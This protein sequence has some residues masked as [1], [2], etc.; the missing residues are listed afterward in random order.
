M[1]FEINRSGLDAGQK[2]LD[3]TS[4]NIANAN[5]FGFKKS[6]A[7]FVDVFS[8]GQPTEAPT[9]LV[10]AGVRTANVGQSFVQ[11][12]LKRTD[13]LFDLSVQGD[14]F[15]VT[16]ATEAFGDAEFTRAGAFFLNKEN[17]IVNA[18]GDYLMG[19]NVSTEGDTID[20]SGNGINSIEVP[21][22]IGNPEATQ[23]ITYQLNMP[24]LESD[25]AKKI[26]AFDPTDSETFN[27][28]TAST[29]YD[30]AGLEHTLN[31]YFIKPSVSRPT[32]FITD[33]SGS[34]IGAVNE[35]IDASFDEFSTQNALP[36]PDVPANE[37]VLFPDAYNN[38]QLYLTFYTVDDK[39]IQ[40]TNNQGGVEASL[41]NFSYKATLDGVDRVINDR[42]QNEDYPNILSTGSKWYGASLM[43]DRGMVTA[44]NPS[45][46]VMLQSLGSMEEP[47][48][49]PGIDTNQVLRI[50]Y[51]G[52]TMFA[53]D[54]QILDH[55]VDGRKPGFIKNVSIDS[56]GMVS[57]LFDNDLRI[58]ISRVSL[59]NF[60][61]VNGLLQ[62]G[63]TQWQHTSES[64]PP[65]F[66]EAGIKG[67]GK[68]ESGTLE[69][70]NVDLS[71]QL[72]DLIVAQRNYQASAKALDTENTMQQ[73]IIQLM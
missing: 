66:G 67:L 21:T 2:Y 17:K 9:A 49:G 32:E 54:F 1:A 7:Q 56:D 28:S 6:R 37:Q 20:L 43:V 29:F 70:S 25:E 62:V 58:P 53:S 73:A 26:D 71:H 35:N 8:S 45:M 68:I 72:I 39:P 12:G 48:L 64:G 3:V 69:Q 55:E 5:S 22:T 44:T 65:N 47:T 41:T 23:N 42:I 19:Y 10:G 40:T 13:N 31:I 18:M 16:S 36:R 38:H 11:G 61:S 57:S 52:S 27:F 14:G 24:Q 34:I 33:A 59:V 63:D 50:N 51:D 4:N 60:T 30:S 46:P 15:F